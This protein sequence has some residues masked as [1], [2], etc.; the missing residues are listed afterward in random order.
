MVALVAVVAL[1]GLAGCK[2]PKA[3]V[4]GTLVRVKQRTLESTVSATGTITPQVGAD[5]KVGP[6]IS[7]LLQKLYVK[8]GD[9]VQTGEVL[10]EIEHADLD[11]AVRD[12]GTA[13]KEARAK[14]DLDKLVLA[15]RVRL[16]REGIVSPEDLDI[17]RETVT[18]DKAALE[19]AQSHLASARIMQG[20]ATVRAPISGTVTAISTQ[21]G[22]TVAASFAVPTFVTIVDLNRLQVD[23][24]VDEVDIGHVKPG[25]SA[26]F[27]VD[28]AP[29]ETF[30]GTVQAV[31]PQAMVR[32]NVV[33]YVVLLT[34]QKGPKGILRPAMTATVSIETGEHRAALVVP[35]GAVQYD[36]QGS[37]YVTVVVKGKPQKKVVVC[38]SQS[39]GEIPIKDGLSEGEEVLLP[40][41]Q[42]GGA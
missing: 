30:H 35:A 33:N 10:A 4:T 32:N 24:Y 36:A 42:S 37:S 12:A 7:G 27:T 23:A 14:L 3:Q 19:S 38:G 26:T 9:T 8:V 6:R 11:Q 22:E 34:I 17:A 15:R 16:E 40:Q 31:I 39:G 21:E 29:S 41:A 1:A 25:Q 2:K 28:A 5:V 20:Y 18:V 13:V